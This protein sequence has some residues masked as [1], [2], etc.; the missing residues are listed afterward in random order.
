MKRSTSHMFLHVTLHYSA[1]LCYALFFWLTSRCV[2][3][4]NVEQWE[5]ARR[6]TWP[7]RPAMKIKRHR[8]LY[9]WQS[10]RFINRVSLCL[11]QEPSR[12]GSQRGRWTPP[13][14]P[15]RPCV[16]Q[17]SRT[18]R[19]GWSSARWD[20]L[21]RLYGFQEGGLWRSFKHPGESSICPRAPSDVMKGYKVL[22]EVTGF[23]TAC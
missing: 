9:I 16:S 15:W 18:H 21:N 6:I 4:Y 23:W 5:H 13:L 19:S 17:W 11:F 20:S 3:L 2:T 8:L 12:T 7:T 10:F 14:G 1:R 22:E